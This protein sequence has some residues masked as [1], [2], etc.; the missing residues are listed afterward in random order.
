MPQPGSMPKLV[1]DHLRKI[2]EIIRTP[3]DFRYTIC[4]LLV[5]AIS[6]KPRRGLNPELLMFKFGIFT[7]AIDARDRAFAFVV[8]AE[9]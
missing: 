8:Q 5:V 4:P 7:A 1:H 2:V 6:W 3:S 9:L